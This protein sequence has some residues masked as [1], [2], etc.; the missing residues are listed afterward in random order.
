MQKKLPVKAT[1][2]NQISS[3]LLENDI[4]HEK[5]AYFTFIHYRIYCV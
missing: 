4:L 2:G 1:F 3:W 5:A